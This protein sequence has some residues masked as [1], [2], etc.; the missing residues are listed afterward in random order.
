VTGSAFPSLE[1]RL[2]SAFPSTVDPVLRPSS[3]ADFQA[4]G[5]I[6]LAARQGRDPRTIADELVAAGRLDEL[7]STVEVT[8]RGFINLTVRSEVLGQMLS[9]LN[10][11]ERIGV[12]LVAEPDIVV[13]DYSA[14]NV[15]K[16]MHVGHLRSTI[17]GDAA[18]RVLAFQGHTVIRANHLGDWGTPFGLL[19]EHLVEQSDVDDVENLSIGDLTAFYEAAR[20]SFDENEPFRERSRQRV[21]ALQSGDP[22]TTRLWRILVTESEKYFLQVYGQLN[23]SLTG[24]DFRGESFYNDHLPATM[25]DL[26]ERG[27]LTESEGALCA[28]PAGFDAPLLVRKTDGGFGYDATDLAA[29][30]Y[31]VGELDATR[32]LY[33]VGSPQRQHFEMVFQTARE[34]GWLGS[35]TPT[36][37]GFGSILGPD[38]RMLRTRA[39]GTVKLRTLID[40]AIARA[41]ALVGPDATA[42][43]A[44]A[45]GV[46]ALKYADLAAH[47]TKD[48]VFDFERMLA[49]DGNTA[50]YVQMARVRALS[51]LR[52]AGD[53]EPSSDIR[54]E[55]PAE[56]GLARAVL[57]FPG[58]VA[59]A[60]ATLEF[61]RLTGHL[62][63][64]AT[65][66]TRLWEA[67]PVL[68]ADPE[69][70][71][72][73]LE[74]CRLTARTIHCGLDLLGIE[75]PA[76][77]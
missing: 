40:E 69:H 19:I 74:L 30:R 62:F 6:A 1:E 73:R 57:A 56:R 43:V 13:V 47:R 59:E 2:I 3:R 5:A 12:P 61:H 58:V 10:G 50:P 31:R 7:C 28:F 24:D 66:F 54:I 38:G 23:V 33:V 25:R 46:G 77:L 37:V 68:R 75:A 42:E 26:A 17:I 36:F 67:D 45:V 64:L 70:R 52:K 16:E 29:I 9:V 39:G 22:E 48:Y 41:T 51:I 34:A 55:T 53:P 14:P 32:L 44:R 27:L 65:A 76:A 35:A 15:A 71:R 20:R 18:A 11:D 4:N 49:L 72:S 60:G 63:A 8:D 21:V